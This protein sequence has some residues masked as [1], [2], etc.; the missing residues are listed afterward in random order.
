MK[1]LVALSG[2][3]DSSVAASML[4]EEG[5]ELVGLTMKNWCYGEDEGDGRSCCSLESIQAARRVADR[6]GFPH[7]V[8]DF[9]AP[10]AT[11][12]IKPFVQDYLDGRTPNPCVSCN[13]K[14]RFPGLWNR[15][16]AY[17]CD[18]F[19]TGHYAR[20]VERDGVHRIAR[21]V[22]PG[23]D[24][25]YMLWGVPSDTLAHLR[26]PLGGLKKTEVRGLASEADLATAERPDSQEICFVP[27]GDYGAFLE[28]KLEERGETA[29]ALEAG[30]VVTAD[31]NVV[32]RHG[33]VARYTIG[34]R[35]GLGVALGRPAYVTAIDRE[36]NRVVVGGEDEL[37][38]DRARLRDV[39]WPEG[40]PP[41]PP[42]GEAG[43]AEPEA[44]RPVL[45]QL[46]SRHRAAP[47]RIHGL[48]D[49]GAEIRFEEAQR[50][51]TPG[52]SAVFYDQDVV[53]GGGIVADP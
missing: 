30:D 53:I 8:V 24:Q 7:Y 16:R 4:A 43:S 29:A 45:V 18:A 19:A 42:V 25:S 23:K 41:L 35:R 47:A 38:S 5:H 26:L 46:R 6:L 10:F 48:P 32:G 21:A 20:V 49:G 22:D 40:E 17:G 1:I 9:E 37:L 36:N 11:H 12:V 34:Q 2:G 44:G 14:V 27:D 28:E 50:A 51:V 31:G 33:G 39:R 15:A 13:T 3:V 52:Q